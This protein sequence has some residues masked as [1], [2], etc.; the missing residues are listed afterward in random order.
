MKYKTNYII[1]IDYKK[2]IKEAA[3]IMKNND[4]GFLPIIKNNKIIGVITDRDIAISFS[5][6][7]DE[8]TKVTKYMTKK[9]ISIKNTASKEEILETMQKY[10]IKRLLVKKEKEVI[11]VISI[12]DLITHSN[13]NNLIIKALKK[14]FTPKKQEKKEETE[15][16]EFYL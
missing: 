4:I 15:I 6:E 12:T 14:I 16:D 5:N 11:G 7:L 10:K 8:T 9:V 2:T 13:D 1:S 3:T